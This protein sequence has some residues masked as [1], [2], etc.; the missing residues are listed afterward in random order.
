MHFL[1][2]NDMLQKSHLQGLVHLN[3][4][5]RDVLLS[6]TT[7]V[8]SFQIG[9]QILQ[10]D[11]H[12]EVHKHATQCKGLQ[13]MLGFGGPALGEGKQIVDV[14]DTMDLQPLGSCRFACY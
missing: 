14:T 1:S 4:R 6:R 3:M 10:P 2:V 8:P 12:P 9:V 7:E 11:V 5:P 13:G